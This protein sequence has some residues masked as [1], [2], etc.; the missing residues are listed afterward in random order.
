MLYP[1]ICSVESIA[2]R[3]DY[4]ISRTY[5]NAGYGNLYEQAGTLFI[6]TRQI[7]VTLVAFP[8]LG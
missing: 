6:R 7:L 2:E 3:F 1:D 8:F 5:V 4:L